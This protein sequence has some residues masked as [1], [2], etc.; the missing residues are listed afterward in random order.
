MSAADEI[1]LI[2]DEQNREVGSA[3]RR[4]MR[5]RR[6]P[7]RCTYVL[8]FDRAGELFVQLRTPVKDIYPSYFDL[9]AGGVINSGES[10]DEAAARELE[11]ELGIS[12]VPLEPHGEIRFEDEKTIVFGRVYSCV[13]EGPMWYQP[14]E[15]VSGKFVPVTE[16]LARVERGDTITPDSVQALQHYLSVNNS[17]L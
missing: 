10:Y 9:A 4:E 5:A 6:L 2:V 11:E 13:Y 16:I 14:E 1:V 17:S 3:T 8:V 12:G 7:H 15:V